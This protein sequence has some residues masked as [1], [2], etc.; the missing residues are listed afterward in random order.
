MTSGGSGG[1]YVGWYVGGCLGSGRG[2]YKP[3]KEQFSVLID[4]YSALL[5]LQCYSCKLVKDRET[6]AKASRDRMI[7]RQAGRTDEKE[8][9]EVQII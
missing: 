3:Q 5:V 6:G 2:T 1:N 8:D 9:R 4:L 7:G